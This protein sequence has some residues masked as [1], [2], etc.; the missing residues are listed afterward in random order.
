MR[1]VEK[2]WRQY[3]MVYKLSARMDDTPNGYGEING[4]DVELS[5]W[6]EEEG[7]QEGKGIGYS[8]NN[9]SLTGIKAFLAFAVPQFGLTVDEVLSALLN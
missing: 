8:G 1:Y 3:G 7:P 2:K 6:N 4:G 9:L 5:S